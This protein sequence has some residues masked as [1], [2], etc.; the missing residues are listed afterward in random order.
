MLKNFSNHFHRNAEG[1]NFLRFTP[2]SGYQ[3]SVGDQPLAHP[4]KS[5]FKVRQEEQP[6]SAQDRIKFAKLWEIGFPI[7]PGGVL[8]SEAYKAFIETIGFEALLKKV[9]EEF[10][11][12]NPSK[13][14]LLNKLDYI[15]REI[16]QADFP[17]TIANDVKQG[18]DSAGLKNRPVAVRSS[19]IGEDSVIA[20]FAGIHQSFLNVH[21]IEN[22][23][24]SI[25]KCYA[26]LW[27][28]Q[29]L[30]YR[31]RKGFAVGSVLPA[32]VIIAMVEA[33][34][35]GVAFTCDPVT[36]NK[37]V[38]AINAGFGFGDILVDGHIDPD[39]YLIDVSGIYP[40]LSLK[41]IGLPG[42]KHS[43]EEWWHTF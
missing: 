30:L 41:K 23:L 4:H 24:D 8:I 9:E 36:G 31:R 14:A 13:P 37:D 20:S 29:A 42:H 5:S 16:S 17:V 3:P 1:R 15:G 19:A 32:I 27:T 7:P 35:S 10:D 2:Y 40:V 21:Y 6:P 38:I 11:I 18:L 43:K 12:L 34:A 26:S 39:H 22:V 25:K 28:P 33:Q